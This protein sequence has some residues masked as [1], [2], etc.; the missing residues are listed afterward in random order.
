MI[1][2]AI[3]YTDQGF[4]KIVGFVKDDNYIINICDSGIG[5]NQEN[6]ENI[7]KRFY[8][9]DKARSRDTGG[10][11]LGLSISK[12]IILKH[13]GTI[14]VES[15]ENKGSTFS[16]TLPIKPSKKE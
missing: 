5:I 7:F 12:N 6:F 14:S 2:N 9:V 11:G 15:T 8:R 10:S 3:N 1:K 13:S 4:I 16:I